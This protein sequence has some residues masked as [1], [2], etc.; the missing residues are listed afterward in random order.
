MPLQDLVDW[1]LELSQFFCGVLDPGRVGGF[2]MFSSAGALSAFGVQSPEKPSV[3]LPPG[4]RAKLLWH[5]PIGPGH[6]LRQ[7]AEVGWGLRNVH[8][9]AFVETTVPLG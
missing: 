7:V 4:N 1:E 5:T 8:I 6:R 2:C 3:I 9:E